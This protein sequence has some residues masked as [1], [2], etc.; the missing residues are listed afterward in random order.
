[1]GSTDSP[2]KKD[3]TTRF[4]VDYQKLNHVTREDAYLLPCID[5]TLDSL[6][7]IKWFSTLDLLSG[8]WQVEVAEKDRQKNVFC[9]T[10]DLFEFK[11]MPFGLCKAPATIQRLMDLLL[12]GLQWSQCLVYI[13]NV[14]VHGQSFSTHLEN[15]QFIFDHLRSAGLK[16]KLT[17]CNFLQHQVKYL[18]HV[19]STDGVTLDPTTIDKVAN[20]RTPT[21]VR[22]IQQFLGLASYYRKFLHGFADLAK[23]LHHLVGRNVSFQWTEDCQT[24]FVELW[25][26]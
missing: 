17:K 4:C 23:P 16:L 1:M 21:T 19:V 7:G 3:G 9:T 26:D 10:E 11:V 5:S 15:L 18:G 22:D 24:S 20:W 14:I 2:G 12:A 8:Y 6:T 25:K 13:D